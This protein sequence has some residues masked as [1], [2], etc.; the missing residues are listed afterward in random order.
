MRFRRKASHPGGFSRAD[1]LAV[2]AA[3]FVFG[4]LLAPGYGQS[5]GNGQLA[6][7]MN[8]LRQLTQ[9]WQ[10]FAEAHDG[11][12]P[13]N[14]AGPDSG[15]N[16]RGEYWVVGWLSWDTQS[17]NTNT[18]KVTDAGL[19]PYVDRNPRVFKCPSDTYISRPQTLRMRERA[20]SYSMNGFV[21]RSR[22]EAVFGPSWHHHEKLQD[23]RPV[24][25]HQLFLL[26]DEHPDSINDS[27]FFVDP[28]APRFVD[29]PAGYHQNGASLSFADGHVEHKIWQEAET[30]PPVRFQFTSVQAR[31]PY[32]DYN[33]LKARTTARWP[34]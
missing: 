33:W 2:V 10:L 14:T 8:N 16:M 25:P 13:K 21:G 31:A 32:L 23:I 28:E 9:A 6:T 4:L 5:L 12:L 15:N 22:S 26:L 11:K 29:Y 20:R 34:Q 30:V 24:P 19:G 1:L 17:D 3:L 27:A 7:C 18:L